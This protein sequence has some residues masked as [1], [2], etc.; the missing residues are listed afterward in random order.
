[1]LA[2]EPSNQRISLPV[3]LWRRVILDLRLRGGRRGES[4]AFLLGPD[5]G[6]RAVATSY[7]CYDDLDPRAYQRG[8]IAF[9]ASGCAALWA[10]C[11]KLRVE[12]LADVHTHPG[13][14]T[15]QSDID[16]RNPMIPVVG[17]TALIV[18]HF[19]YSPW[20]TLKGVGIYE[21][22]GGFAWRP[23][24]LGGKPRVALTLW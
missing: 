6:D 9:H 5:A 22:V 2:S 1:M 15:G 17:H 3:L 7:I 13:S 21:Y 10:H 16:Q 8:G 12:V 14:A 11:R 20:W 19:G 24:T 18:P 4:G 23:H